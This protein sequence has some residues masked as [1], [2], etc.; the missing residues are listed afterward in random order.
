MRVSH[1]TVAAV[2]AIF[3]PWGELSPVGNE[4]PTVMAV[5]SQA[6]SDINSDARGYSRACRKRRPTPVDL[7]TERVI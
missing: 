2:L 3:L 6:H 7:R 4:L 5:C 1:L